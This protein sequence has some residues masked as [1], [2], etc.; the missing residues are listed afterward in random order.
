MQAV[1]TEMGFSLKSHLMPHRSPVAVLSC[2]RARRVEQEVG[3]THEGPVVEGG[4]SLGWVPG[5][6]PPNPPPQGP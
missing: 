2:Q 1:S 5:P 3:P 4:R 6:G